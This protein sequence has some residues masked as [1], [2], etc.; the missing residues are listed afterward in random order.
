MRRMLFC[1]AAVVCLGL[2]GCASTSGGSSLVRERFEVDTAHVAA[3]NALSVRRG[4]DVT[5]VNPPIKRVPANSG[6]R[7]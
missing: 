3:V 6:L 7:E 2:P 4:V 5:W 1:A